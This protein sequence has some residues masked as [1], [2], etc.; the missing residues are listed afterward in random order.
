MNKYF[1]LLIEALHKEGVVN[2]RGEHPLVPSQYYAETGN[3]LVDKIK[4]FLN[5]KNSTSIAVFVDGVE[6]NTVDS[7]LPLDEFIA[8][9]FSELNVDNVWINVSDLLGIDKHHLHAST[10]HLEKLRTC[11]R[12][13]GSKTICVLGSGTLTDL[14]KHALYLEKLN[15]PFCVVP[16]ALTVTAFTSSFAVLETSGAKRTQISQAIGAAFWYQ[17]VLSCAPIQMS[18][19]GYGDLLARFVAYSD[20]YLGHKL[21]VMDRYDELAFRLMEPFAEVLKTGATGFA[22]DVLS[23]E[24]VGATSAALSMAGI[25]MSVSGETTPLSGYEHV[26]SHAL[27]FLRMTSG[28]E[29][30]LHGEQ[31]ALACLASAATQDWILS[32][33]KFNVSKFRFL[34]DEGAGELIT[35]MINQAPYYPERSLEEMGEDLVLKAKKQLAAKEFHKEYI[36]KNARWLS[37][38]EKIAEILTTQ[39]DEIKENIR[40]LSI[41]ESELIT[42]LEQAK[43]PLSPESTSPTT[44]SLEY[45][46]AVRFSP[47]VRA[48]MSVADFVFWVGEDP[49]LTSTI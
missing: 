6:K 46:W 27:D 48:R 41:R 18:R 10:D 32:Q 13:L 38:K 42:L 39:W 29:L 2:D 17:G 19:A 16:T 25:A 34:S 24:S 49:A 35:Q 43:L 3:D 11:L 14:I 26:I 21:G 1:K 22:G 36:K 33:E 28:R 44:T 7:P 45:R 37:Q 5:Q 47:F 8:A 20:W 23:A 30:V 31:V 4:N 9:K 40:R 12:E 15:N